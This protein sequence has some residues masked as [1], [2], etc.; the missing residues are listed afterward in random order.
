LTATWRR[1]RVGWLVLLNPIADR[2]E[3]GA[4]GLPV[5]SSSTDVDERRTRARMRL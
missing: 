3:E 4:V 1:L 2:P 5:R